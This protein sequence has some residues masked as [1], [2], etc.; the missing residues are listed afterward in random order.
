[1][2]I[3]IGCALF[4]WVLDLWGLDLPLG[5]SVVQSV[6][7]IFATLLLAYV[8]WEI[9]RTII[10]RKLEEDR[11]KGPVRILEAV[12]TTAWAAGFG[13]GPESDQGPVEEVCP[14]WK[15]RDVLVKPVGGK[16]CAGE[17]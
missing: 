7:S 15:K 12:G 2:G 11:A 17:I 10:D 5:R 14:N 1:M 8:V 16:G 13:A 4:F 3:L 9:C 6:S